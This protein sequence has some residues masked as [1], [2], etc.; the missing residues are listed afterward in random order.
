MGG[1]RPAAQVGYLIAVGC[2]VLALIGRRGRRG[3]VVL[4][5]RIA[6][7]PAN[8]FAVVLAPLLLAIVVDGISRQAYAARYLSM[9]A[10]L[11]FVVVGCGIAVLPSRRARRTMLERLFVAGARGRD[12]K[13]TVRR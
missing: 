5:T 10:G 8:L 2:V 6:R 9:G 4:Q 13:T 11:F 12:P 7:L 3:E 1:D